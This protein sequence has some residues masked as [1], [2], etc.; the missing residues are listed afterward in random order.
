MAAGQPIPFADYTA[1]QLMAMTVEGG[2]GLP[3]L[4]WPASTPP[5]LHRLA[6]AC[7]GPVPSARPGAKDVANMLAKIEGWVW[8]I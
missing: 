2:D 7:M 4:S 5:A 6:K 8:S 3:S 1:W